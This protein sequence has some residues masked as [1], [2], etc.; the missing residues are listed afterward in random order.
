M[1]PDVIL[2]EVGGSVAPSRKSHSCWVVE[3]YSTV[4]D[5]VIANA[6]GPECRSSGTGTWDFSEECW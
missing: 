3:S 1:G 6:E 4:L 5:L 2:L